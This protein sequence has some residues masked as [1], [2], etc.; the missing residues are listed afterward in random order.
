MAM[1]ESPFKPMKGEEF[2]GLVR[3]NKRSIVEDIVQLKKLIVDV[4]EVDLLNT[5]TMGELVQ[6]MTDI[7]KAEKDSDWLKSHRDDIAQTLDHLNA[8]GEDLVRKYAAFIEEMRKDNK[9]DMLVKELDQRV[10]EL[11]KNT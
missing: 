9:L 5:T 11:T 1:A 3:L 8:F 10:D 6:D 7:Y 4:M 2:E